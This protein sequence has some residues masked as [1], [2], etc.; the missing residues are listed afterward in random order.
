MY[1]CLIWLF[2]GGESEFSVGIRRVLV[3]QVSKYISF[4]FDILNRIT[5]KLSVGIFPILS[6][7]C[8]GLQSICFELS[9]ETSVDGLCSLQYSFLSLDQYKLKK[10]FKLSVLDI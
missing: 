6:R 9:I 1:A 7:V 4:V 5:I 3:Q 2:G 8:S 10:P